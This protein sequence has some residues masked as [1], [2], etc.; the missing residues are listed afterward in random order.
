M[1]TTFLLHG[2]RLRIQDER[3]DGYFKR[4]TRDL[5]DGDQVLFIGF[6]RIGAENSMLSMIKKVLDTRANE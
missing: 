3:N 6:A 4:L 1:K 5:E 2:E